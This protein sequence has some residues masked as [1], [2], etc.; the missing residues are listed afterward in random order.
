LA[1]NPRGLLIYR[2]ELTAFVG[3]LNQ[4]RDGGLGADQQFYMS[5]WSGVPI[6]VDRKSTHKQGPISVPH[7]HLNIFGGIVPDN[8]VVMRGNKRRAGVQD[9]FIDR[10]LFSY[11]EPGEQEEENYVELPGELVALYTSKLRSLR[12]LELDNGKPTLISWAGDGREAWRDFTRRH[13]AEMNDPTF[14]QPLKGPWVKLKAY[15]ARFALLL[16]YLRWA[17]RKAGDVILD[18]VDEKDLLNAT[19]LIDYFKNHAKRVYN[20]IDADW[21]IRPARRVLAWLAS[22]RGDYFAKKEKNAKGFYEIRSNELHQ[23]VWGG[24]FP[25]ED[26]EKVFDLLVLHNYLRPVETAPRPGP[27]RKPTSRYEVHPHSFS[28]ENLS[29]FSQFSRNDDD[30]NSSE[31]PFREDSSEFPF[32]EN[33][34]NCETS[35][36]A[37]DSPSE[38]PPSPKLLETSV[39]CAG[40]EETTPPA[41]KLRRKRRIE[42]HTADPKSTIERILA[43][44]GETKT[45]DQILAEWPGDGIRRQLLVSTLTKGAQEGW[46]VV[47]GAGVRGDPKRF[48]KCEP[49]PAE[50]GEVGKEDAGGEESF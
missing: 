44:S 39:F 28:P 2:D 8:L 50:G 7:P 35:P 10:F 14:P 22:H 11:P 27:G 31:F 34:E 17:G 20:I 42:A 32:R 16:H 26:G 21:R 37:E 24:S 47:A 46:W 40:D 23:K 6:T 4:Y 1:D 12:K 36:E 45:I 18:G 38:A 13:A 3:S 33:C 29:Q 49:S 41:Q 9:G 30:G 5:G 48:S 43:Q 15:C 25:I 19:L